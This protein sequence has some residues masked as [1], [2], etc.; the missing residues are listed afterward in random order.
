M[1]QPFD[2]FVK[3]QDGSI[4]LRHPTYDEEFHSIHGA[5]R[6]ADC[7]YMEAS[8]FRKL[9]SQPQTQEALDVLDVGL[10]L[11]YN[12][13]MTI[14]CWMQGLGESDLRLV[15]LEQSLEL[16]QSLT[17]PSCPW[18]EG[19]SE[20]WKQWALSL[21]AVGQIAE[22]QSRLIHPLTGRRLHWIVLIGDA[23]QANLSAF[24]FDYIWQDAFSPKKN[25]ELW[26]EEWFTKLRRH[27]AAKVQLVSYS[28][29]R[30]VRDHLEA[31]GWSPQ[32]VKTPEI[33]GLGVAGKR[34]WLLASLSED[35]KTI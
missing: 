17:D 21:R 18:K 24:A 6:E 15:S 28:V 31:A 30:L 12:A 27:S 16:V 20:D 2:Q 23:R 10:G 19:W 14:E 26:S 11:A 8:G 5:R 13:L 29:A 25:P 33:P 1:Q 32:R 35:L 34:N 4:T 7:L 9:L 22:W 3:T